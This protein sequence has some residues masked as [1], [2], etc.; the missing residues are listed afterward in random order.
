MQDVDCQ[1]F[2]EW[3]ATCLA[4]AE[5]RQSLVL[6]KGGIHERGGRF[7]VEQTEFWLFPTQ[8]HQTAADFRPDAA[9]LVARAAEVAPP[10]ESI[11]I[12][13]YAVVEQVIE[14]V[15]QSLLARLCELQILSEATLLRRFR[16]RSPGLFV[17]PVRIYRL[18]EPMALEESPHFA[19]CR[20]WVNL[21]RDLPTSDLSP[22]LA[23]KVHRE[24]LS[25]IRC[26]LNS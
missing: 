10:S 8:F 3:A 17:F 11:R 4:L 19:G 12:E 1:A 15:D 16:Y 24:R 25:Q 22:V 9:S 18:R 20:T 7:V 5:G 26:A 13:L 6:R 2:K 23:E 21:E 14:L